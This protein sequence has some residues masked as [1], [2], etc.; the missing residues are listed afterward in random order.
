[1]PISFTYN[2]SLYF[3]NTIPIVTT[4]ALFPYEVYVTFDRCV[5]QNHIASHSCQLGSR[6]MCISTSV[7]TIPRLKSRLQTFPL[8]RFETSLFIVVFKNVLEDIYQEHGV[9]ITLSVQASSHGG[10]V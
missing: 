6:Q 9:P 10:N 8:P 2:M 1:M 4:D 5:F 7:Y 3:I